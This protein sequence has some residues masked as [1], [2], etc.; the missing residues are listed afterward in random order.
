MEARAS[1]PYPQEPATGP[2]P[3]PDQPSPYH[4]MLLLL[5]PS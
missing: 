2:Y 1:L 5:D 3:E 4:P